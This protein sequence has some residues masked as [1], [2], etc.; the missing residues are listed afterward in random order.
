M[1]RYRLV[2]AEGHEFEG[3][4][5]SGAAFETQTARCQVA[6]PSCGSTEVSKAVM[7][8]NVATHG[9]DEAPAAEEPS[10]E[11]AAQAAMIEAARRLRSEVTRKAEYV[12]PRFAEEARRM[13]YCETAAR[14]IYGEAS[15]KE[16]SDLLEE[17]IPVWP[18]PRLPEDRN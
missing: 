7:A 10:A 13:H 11:A 3:W 5:R 18:M 12:G 6:C 17:G 1:I 14:S 4:F 15:G 9:R 16:A 8:P 2:C